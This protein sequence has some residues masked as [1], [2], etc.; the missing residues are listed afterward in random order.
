MALTP[1]T[2]VD[3]ILAAYKDCGISYTTAYNMMTRHYPNGLDI[4]MV[5]AADMLNSTHRDCGTPVPVVPAPMAPPIGGQA[6]ISGSKSTIPDNFFGYLML[7][8][9]L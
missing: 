4:P 9:G 6:A 3:D 8:G 1:G 5:A 2:T 7:V